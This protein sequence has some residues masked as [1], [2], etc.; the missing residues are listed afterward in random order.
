[1]AQVAHKLLFTVEN[2]T[3]NNACKVGNAVYSRI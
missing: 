2:D 1:M 3:S